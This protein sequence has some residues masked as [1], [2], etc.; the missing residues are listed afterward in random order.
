MQMSHFKLKQV[1]DKL[2]LRKSLCNVQNL[3]LTLNTVKVTNTAVK[4][5]S[6]LASAESTEP[7]FYP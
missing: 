6:H 3:D 5:S 2:Y 1:V 7:V 4:P